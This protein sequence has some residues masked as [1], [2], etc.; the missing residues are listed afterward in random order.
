M[1]TPTPSRRMQLKERRAERAAVFSL[2]LLL[3]LPGLVQAQFDYSVLHQ[4]HGSDGR[5]PS[6]TLALSGGTL[7]G[8][9][10]NG[11]V[12]DHGTVF[13]ISTNGSGFSVLHYFSTENEQAPYGGVIASGGRLYGVAWGGGTPTT[14]GGV[15]ALNCDGSAYSVL[16]S[17]SGSDGREPSSGLVASGMTLFGTTYEGGGSGYGTVFKINTD[18]SAFTILKE[19][20]IADG[21]NPQPLVCSGTTFYGMAA[22]GGNNGAGVLFRMNTDGTGYTVLRY[23]SGP[24]GSW[25]S[26]S[27]VLSGTTLYGTTRYGGA[28]LGAVFA[29]NVDGTGFRVLKTFTTADGGGDPCGG[30]ILAGT[31]LYGTL[32]QGGDFGLGAVFKINTDGSNYSVLKSFNG[33]SDG[34]LPYG[35][36]AFLGPTLYGTAQQGGI[37]DCGVVFSLSLPMPSIQTPP[38]TQTAELGSTPLFS[39][40][41]IAD[42]SLTYQW[43]FN[44]TNAVTEAT[45]NP[46]FGLAEVAFSQA[47]AYSVVVSND[48]GVVT[49]TPAMLSV[50]PPVPRRTVPALLLMG[51]P[52]N[53]LDVDYANSLSPAP[54]W[55]LL[56]SI[57]L[58]VTSGY[59][60]DLTLPLPPQR[61][62]RAWQTIPPSQPPILDL[63]LVPAITL[64]GAVGSSVRVD[65]INQFG[66]IDA[67]VTLDTVTLTNTPQLYFDVSA[68]G[69]PQRL[70][71]LATLP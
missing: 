46:V 66:P 1:T 27:L 71:R 22:N 62:Y 2:L 9:T 53:G 45:T 39:V 3:T 55:T 10:I 20:T 31:R 57:S 68:P 58:T 54:N 48:F 64:T 69:Q 36:L 42:P 26:G 25:P 8:A 30:L 23:F 14:C 18:G 12:N 13:R 47:G 63:H 34:Y 40:K 37:S 7:Y 51:Q 67:W 38:R 61:F 35:S 29:V 11:G 4:F 15:F 49:S 56:G 43:F 17:F 60:F 21:V 28:G 65:Y 16:H 44:G 19:F 59:C 70:Y 50:I 33:R 52:G 5:N 32:V 24:D 41:T 6:A